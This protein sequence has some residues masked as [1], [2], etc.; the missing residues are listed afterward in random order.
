[1]AIRTPRKIPPAIPA[2]TEPIASGR[3]AAPVTIP[4]WALDGSRPGGS[5]PLAAPLRL[6]ID[7]VLAARRW[8]ALLDDL[9][10]SRGQSAARMEA[11]AVISRSPPDSA[12]IEIARRIGIEG[13]TFTRMLDADG[14]VARRPHPTDRRTKHIRLTAA[15]ETALAEILGMA[16]TLR[17]QVLA[18]MDQADIDHTNTF[19]E[20]FIARMDQGLPVSGCGG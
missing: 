17:T 14:M 8:R 1:M 6:T 3:V 9:L 7:V 13:A 12:Q 15:G 4:P 11:M 20:A 19:L 2:T 16:E 5:T 18:G 10:R